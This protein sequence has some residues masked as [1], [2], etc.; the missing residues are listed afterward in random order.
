MLLG[1]VETGSEQQA[2]RQ[3]PFRTP[4]PH[5]PASTQPCFDAR[6]ALANTCRPQPA[7]PRAHLQQER[8]QAKRLEQAYRRCFEL[9]AEAHAR[10][11]HGAAAE[12]SMRVG[13]GPGSGVART[14]SGL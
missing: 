2:A 11:D 5:L 6:C 1:P 13:A 10:G 3:A 8:A 14:R 12:L 9:A 4:N 7:H